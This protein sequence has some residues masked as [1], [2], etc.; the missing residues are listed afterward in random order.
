MVSRKS[1]TKVGLPK[2][3]SE[4]LGFE[5]GFGFGL[6]LGLGFGFGFGSRV[7]VS[8]ST[9]SLASARRSTYYLLLTTYYLLL[10]TYY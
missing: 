4:K 2:V 10:T 5:F 8:G 1:Y 3:T 7:R 6:C 9:P